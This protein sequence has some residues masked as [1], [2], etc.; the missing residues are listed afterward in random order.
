MR[1]I[2]IPLQL[3]CAIASCG[4]NRRAEASVVQEPQPEAVVV[5]A[6]SLPDTVFVSQPVP[7]EVERRI[8]GVSL[9]DGA[10][11]TLEQLRYLRLSYCDFDG[12]TQTGELICNAK[13]ADDLV[14]IFR[15][16]YRAGYPIRSIRLIDDFGG[17]DDASM[18]ADNTS[19]FNYRPVAGGGHLSNHAFGLA[20]D[21]NPLENPYI[22]GSKILPPTGEPF[23]DRS[24]DFPHKI[25]KEDLC[26][27]LFLAHGFEWG[28]D[29]HSLKD[30]QHFK[31]KLQ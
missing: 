4:G 6:V 3:L 15:E 30:Y 24:K 31:K 27:K 1:R 26:Y 5:G 13:I 10:V 16:L 12:N 29:W 20:I 11:I 22:K 14:A 7:P 18:E 17:S 9:P 8:R 2:L 28:G 21:V 23:V 19:C 25:D